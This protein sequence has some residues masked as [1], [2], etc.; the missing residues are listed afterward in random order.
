MLQKLY[1]RQS[2]LGVLGLLP[3]ANSHLC[4]SNSPCPSVLIEQCFSHQEKQWKR[5]G[6]SIPTQDPPHR[7]GWYSRKSEPGRSWCRG[8][9]GWKG[10]PWRPQAQQ[11]CLKGLTHLQRDRVN[12]MPKGMIEN[13]GI[14]WRK[15]MNTRLAA[16]WYKSI[17]SKNKVQVSLIFLYCFS[18]LYSIYFHCHLYNVFPSASMSLVSSSFSIFLKQKFRLLIWGISS[19]L[20]SAFVL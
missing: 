19:F 8:L 16:P 11:F 4:G 1:F 14:S 5:Q 9:A 13:N 20:M 18:N 17:I 2:G 6:A 12:T 3:P 10:S 15:A 7:A